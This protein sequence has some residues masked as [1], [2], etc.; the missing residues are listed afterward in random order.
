M[1]TPRMIEAFR[2]VVISGSVSEAASFLH[3]TQP[4]V[5][6]LIK[7]MELEVGFKL[8]ERRQGRIFANEDALA[9]Y[10]EVNS[11]YMGLERI[12]KAA[13][14][15]KK[16]ETGTLRIA[17]LPAVGLSIMPKVIS[18]FNKLHPNIDIHLQVVRS[19]TVIQFLTAMQCD[20]GFVEETFSAPSLI[21]GPSF[22]LDTVC[23]M[24]KGHELENYDEI[25]PALIGTH[26]MIALDSDSK[27]RM[28][29]DAIFDAAGTKP[30]ISIVAPITNVVSSLVLEGCGVALVDPLTA[31]SFVSREIVIKPFVPNVPFTFRAFSSSRISRTHLIDEFYQLF[32][33]NVHQICPLE[34]QV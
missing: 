34:D 13:E 1:I 11:F 28:K 9:L 5:S 2:A 4:A 3:I 32:T 8:F 15:I 30:S 16:R 17:S 33:D 25:T 18:A 6:R 12:Q 29:T 27:V 23:I 21:V 24:P 7:D 19:P 20:I 31:D 10:D 26:P 14:Q 22:D